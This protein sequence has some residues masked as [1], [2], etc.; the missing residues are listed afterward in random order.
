[1]LEVER[2]LLQVA[3]CL[4]IFSE[5]L[6]FQLLE[7]AGLADKTKPKKLGASVSDVMVVIEVRWGGDYQINGFRIQV[8]QRVQKVV[9]NNAASGFSRESRQLLPEPGNV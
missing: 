4:P 3:N 7:F 1:M 2:D 9:G 6:R 8:M 5:V